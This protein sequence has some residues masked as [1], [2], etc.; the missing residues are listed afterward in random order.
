MAN[1]FLLKDLAKLSGYSVHTVKYYLKIGLIYEQGRS[2]ETNYRYFNDENLQD[3]AFIR[4]LR[5]QR[6]S[7]EDIRNILQARNKK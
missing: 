2:P 3:L 7:I 6:K 1:L 5:R 4:S